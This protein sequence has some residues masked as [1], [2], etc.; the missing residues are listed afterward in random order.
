[1]FCFRVQ[2][3]SLSDENQFSKC[4]YANEVT[5]QEVVGPEALAILHIFHHVISKLVHVSWGPGENGLKRGT[6][7]FQIWSETLNLVNV[8]VTGLW[9]AATGADSMHNITD[10]ICARWHRPT[11][12]H[13][14]V[15]RLWEPPGA[16]CTSSYNLTNEDTHL[17]T[18]SGVSI[19]QSISRICSSWMKCCLHTCRMLFFRAQPMGPKSY[20]PLTPAGH[21]A[22]V[23]SLAWLKRDDNPYTE[24]KSPRGTRTVCKGLKRTRKNV[25]TSID[26]K[27]LVVKE[28]SLEGVLHL[29]SVNNVIFGL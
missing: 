11:D 5:F 18:G 10:S 25:S 16:L 8:S 17:R 24:L 4:I 26:S 22:S 2:G 13:F 28:P 9:K 21:G 19:V 1:M 14:G 20:S 15:S 27:S 29:G 12:Q 6:V 3:N 23:R 7:R